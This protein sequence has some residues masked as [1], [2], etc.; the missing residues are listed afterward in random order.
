MKEIT[1]FRV[2]DRLLIEYGQSGHEVE[3]IAKTGVNNA[4]QF[5][6]FRKWR[7]ILTDL[8]LVE[9]KAVVLPPKPP[10]VQL[11]DRVLLAL[12]KD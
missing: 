1:E 4:I 11:I 2:G 6:E 8:D 10:K 12:F 7:E 5:V 3:I 9:R